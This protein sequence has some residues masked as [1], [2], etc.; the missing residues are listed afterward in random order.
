MILTFWWNFKPSSML[1]TLDIFETVVWQKSGKKVVKSGTSSLR[2]VW[3]RL[4]AIQGTIRSS[5]TLRN[6]LQERLS[7]T[8][9][10]ESDLPVLVRLGGKFSCRLH[11][12]ICSSESCCVAYCLYTISQD[13][14]NRYWGEIVNKIWTYVDW[15]T[16]DYMWRY[17]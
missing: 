3:K 7:I 9:N 13:F 2:N 4:S 12:K 6:L 5:K 1:K 16:I 17:I 10:F 14:E 15:T 11:T 8:R